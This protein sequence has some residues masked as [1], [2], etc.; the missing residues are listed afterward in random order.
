[1][2]ITNAQL[3]EA[4]H[5]ACRIEET[6]RGLQPF[7]FT[8]QEQALY[9]TTPPEHSFYPKSFSTAGIRLEFVTDSEM[10]AFGALVNT[11]SAHFS[12]CQFDIVKNNRLLANLDVSNI[13]NHLYTELALGEG[14]KHLTIYF[15]WAASTILECLILDDGATFLPCPRKSKMLMYGDSIT[16][17]Y[18]CFHP[19]RSYASL[20][21]D[22]LDA[23]AI[24]KG[25]GGERFRPDL[26]ELADPSLSPDLIT[27]AYGTND[28]AVHCATPEELEH[29]GKAFLTLLSQTYP[30]A[31]I[32][33]ITPIWREDLERRRP[34]MPPFSWIDQCLCSVTDTLPNAYIIH[35][36]DLVPHDPSLYYDHYLHPNDQGFAHYAE[37]LAKQIQKIL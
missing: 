25:I 17:G 32:A 1:M 9:A 13:E 20:L 27:V 19:S 37:N 15:P 12:H 33:V 35:G 36:I 24:N 22:H 3:R 28:W 2:K 30:H 31:N 14:E 29:T 34:S 6:E 23:D 18:H 7:R 5:G 4:F 8:E 10:L 21:A 11:A 16:Q 26:A